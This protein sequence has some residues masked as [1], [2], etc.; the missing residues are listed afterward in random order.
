MMIQGRFAPSPT[1]PLHLG[2]LLAAL[3]SF[4]SVKRRGGNWLVRFDD[5]DTPR[6]VPGAI[7]D[8]LRT[9]ANHGLV[10][11]RPPLLQSQRV[12][13]YQ[14]A[15][16][17][18]QSLDLTFAC[19]CSRKDLRGERI[20]PGTCRGLGLPF[21]GNAMRL[22]MPER[23]IRLSDHI[24]G[25]HSLGAQREV[26]DIILWRRDGN[27]AYHLACAVDDAG[28]QI[29]EV[30]RGA[31]LLSETPAQIVLME[32]LGLTVP[33]YAHLPLVRHPS[34]VKLSKQTHAPAVDLNDPAENLRQCLQWL[35]IQVPFVAK[36]WTVAA[37]LEFSVQRFSLD[38]VPRVLPI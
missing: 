4:L 34:G 14:S 23:T 12:A 20:Y 5:M 22:K 25:V 28:G 30:V 27:F 35:G 29:T 11:D 33:S 15:L 13:A 38:Q 2:S 24:H 1:G 16:E 8:I 36:S 26:G 21:Q 18:L 31:D 7:E 17:R 3:G 9:L 19:Q 37:L 32:L 6:N 10:P